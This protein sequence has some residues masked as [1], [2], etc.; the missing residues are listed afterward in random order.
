MKQTLYTCT[1][2]AEFINRY[3]ENCRKVN[4]E[5]NIVTLREGT[6]GYGNMVLM[7]DGF[8]T[9]I[10][11]ERYLNCWSSGHTIRLYNKTPKKYLMLV[12]R[13]EE[14]YDTN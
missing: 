9:A 12:A 4:K 10:I 11:Q 1:A 3:T 8:K 5:P 13:K 2:V 7:C 6:L 14:E